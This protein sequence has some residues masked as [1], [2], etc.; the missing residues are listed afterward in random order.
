MNFALYL[1]VWQLICSL[2]LVLAELRFG[3][4]GILT[5]ELPENTGIRT[6]AI[7]MVTGLIFGISTYGYV[8]SIERAGTVSAAIAIQSYPVFAILWETIFLDRRKNST[9]LLFT[10]LLIVSLY[11]V[12]TSGT[13]EVEGISLWFLVALGVPFLWSVAHVII[14]EILDKTPITPGQ[15]TFFRVLVSSVALFAIALLVNGSN[16]VFAGVA[17]MKFQMFAL[18][19]GFVYYVEL[20]VWFYAVRH[21]DVSVASSIT[22]PWPVVTMVLAGIF[23]QETIV[24]YQVVAMA[25][26][27]ISI[28]GLLY[29]GKK[30]RAA[31]DS[32]G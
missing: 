12:G 28:Y 3:N 26:V 5:A 16:S 2:P 1:S 10:G 17:D 9:E 15:V 21:V 24:G 32:Q 31:L 4:P 29:A 13:W 25:F 14:K 19:M 23:L 11:Y 22:T 8:L 27:A 6:V 20:V 30:K 18:V 7:I